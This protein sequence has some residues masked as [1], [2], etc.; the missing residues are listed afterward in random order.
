VE[1][2]EKNKDELKSFYDRGLISR[3]E[4]E[5]MGEELAYKRVQLTIPKIWH[6]ETKIKSQDILIPEHNTVTKNISI[7]D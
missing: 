5:R 1:E 4:F 6:E 2:W 3:E 7:D